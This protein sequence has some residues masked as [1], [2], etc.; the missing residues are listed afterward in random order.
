MMEDAYLAI[1]EPLTRAQGLEVNL[2]GVVAA[3]PFDADELV[4]PARGSNLEGDLRDFVG[5]S[6]H[7]PRYVLLVES[8]LQ[9]QTFVSDHLVSAT[10]W[11]LYAAQESDESVQPS[12]TFCSFNPRDAGSIDRS[13][14]FLRRYVEQYGGK[15]IYTDFDEHTR[16]LD[17]RYFLDDIMNGRAE[18]GQGMAEISRWTHVVSGFY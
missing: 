3:L 6:L 5:T 17:A 7:V 14:D 8:S 1:Q 9:M 10:A 12:F 4:L 11:T 18:P 2:T 16:R 15:R 13:A